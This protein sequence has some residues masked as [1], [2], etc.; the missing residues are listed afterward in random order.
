MLLLIL[1]DIVILINK[2]HV[3]LSLVRFRQSP[4]S[5]LSLSS[6]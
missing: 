3:P 6:D 2:I 1:S 5:S 4:S